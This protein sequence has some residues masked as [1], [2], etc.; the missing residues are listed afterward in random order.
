MFSDVLCAPGFPIDIFSLV[1]F[2]GLLTVWPKAQPL[3]ATRS[4]EGLDAVSNMFQSWRFH[5]IISI[6][7]I[8]DSYWNTLK[9][10]TVFG[11]RFHRGGYATWPLS[12]QMVQVTSGEAKHSA[13]ADMM[14]IWIELDWYG[15]SMSISGLD[16][17]HLVVLV[18]CFR[19][20]KA[21]VRPRT[22][23]HMVH[24]L[25]PT[26]LTYRSSVSIS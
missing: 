18:V 7:I 22:Q 6:S 26:M 16:I 4:R 23:A 12:P 20:F 25:L 24:V 21:W 10:R 2:R 17:C 1:D 14:L 13:D 19:A 9:N 3:A 11:H 5:S 15:Q 8:S